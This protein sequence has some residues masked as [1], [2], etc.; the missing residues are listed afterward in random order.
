MRSP[1]SLTCGP[2]LDPTHEGVGFR[3]QGLG[4]RVQGSGFR[5]RVQGLGFGSGRSLTPVAE[6][7]KLQGFPTSR[8]AMEDRKAEAQVFCRLPFRKGPNFKRGGFKGHP[9]LQY[10]FPLVL[11]RE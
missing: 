6:G 3:V 10:I 8:V 9:A 2:G 11:S 4:F 7:T 5:F 1:T